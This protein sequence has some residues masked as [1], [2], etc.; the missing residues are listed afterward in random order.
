[1]SSELQL[2]NTLGVRSYAAQTGAFKD[3]SDSP[4]AFLERCLEVI[5]AQEDGV[6]AFVTMHIEGACA[7]ADASNRQCHFQ[8]SESSML[9][10]PSVTLPLMSVGGLPVGAQ[11]K[12]SPGH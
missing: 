10:A 2:G 3:G 8:L 4:R 9:F 11:V 12:G 5:E 7:A 6:G 1:M